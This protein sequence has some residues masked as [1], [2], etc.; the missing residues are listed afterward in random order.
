MS[1]KPHVNTFVEG[2]M[3]PFRTNALPSLQLPP[4]QETIPVLPLPIKRSNT[5]RPL[6]LDPLTRSS[7]GRSA[8]EISGNQFSTTEPKK[9]KAKCTGQETATIDTE[10]GISDGSRQLEHGTDNDIIPRLAD[11]P[12]KR[13]R[14]GSRVDRDYVQLPLLEKKKGSTAGGSSFG[15]SL[16]SIISPIKSKPQTE[17][18]SSMPFLYPP[19]ATED[20]PRGYAPAVFEKPPR[21]IA[22]SAFEDAH[23]R[24]ALNGSSTAMA[25]LDIG[26]DHD[27]TLKSMESKEEKEPARGSG[28]KVRSRQNKKWTKDE[29]EELFKAIAKHGVGHW[30]KMSA[31][32]EFKFNNRSKT[33]L[34][35]R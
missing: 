35:D 31:D 30:A 25:D 24:N 13:Q 26:K 16:Q 5:N 28:K 12:R 34:K 23:G 4:L 10:E 6:P 7:S 11:S 15:V 22:S 8:E 14:R 19:P 32:A 17:Y 33:D 29:T 20:P 21:G 3:G 9:S 18:S 27:N 1:N 2:S